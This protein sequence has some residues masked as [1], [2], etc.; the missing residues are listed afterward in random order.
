MGGCG[1]R[2]SRHVQCVYCFI[3]HPCIVVAESMSNNDLNVSAWNGCES[4]IHLP[5][6][7]AHR[8]LLETAFS[9]ASFFM[10]VSN[11]FAA[12]T[13]ACLIWPS[14]ISVQSLKS[15]FSMDFNSLFSNSP[16]QSLQAHRH[17]YYYLILFILYNNIIILI[18]IHLFIIIIIVICY[19]CYYY[20]YYYYCYYYQYYCYYSYYY[21]LL[22]L[23]LLFII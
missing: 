8:F 21:Y 3:D 20:S 9:S 19:F 11:A 15:R 10:R 22:L 23:L 17:P 7:Y 1:N 12:C 6:N 18:I 13:N 5:T 14:L 2:S 16:A 4:L